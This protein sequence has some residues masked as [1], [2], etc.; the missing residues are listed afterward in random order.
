MHLFMFVLKTCVS[1]ATL[2]FCFRLLSS[3]VVSV[4]TTSPAPPLMAPVMPVSPA[5]MVRDA[6]GRARLVTMVTAARRSVHIAEI[7]NPVTQ[8]LGNVGG[9]TLDT[10]DPG[11]HYNQVFYWCVKG[12]EELPNRVYLC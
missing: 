12:M 7:M 3:V 6:T 9:V 10:L 8:K 1:L 2:S 4:K 11:A 5:G